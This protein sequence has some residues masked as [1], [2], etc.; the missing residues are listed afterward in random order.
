MKTRE[1]Y[2]KDEAEKEKIKSEERKVKWTQEIME[3]IK[4]WSIKELE[5]EIVKQRL[6]RISFS[7]GFP[8][9]VIWDFCKEECR[10]CGLEYVEGKHDDCCD[11]CWDEN[12]DKTL[13]ELG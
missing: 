11:D 9:G 10:F 1:E 4:G 8:V 12:K 3:E 2:I 13:E 5:E 7:P 6:A